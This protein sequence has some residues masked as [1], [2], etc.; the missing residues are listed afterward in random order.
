MNK[1][2]WF[3]QKDA[4]DNSAAALL[5]LTHHLNVRVSRHTIEETLQAH[6][7]YPSLLAL[8]DALTEWNV[9]NTGVNAELEHLESEE[10]SFPAI[11][12][13]KLGFV[14]L[15]GLEDDH[16]RY[17]DLSEGWVRESLEEFGEKWAGTLILAKADETSGEKDYETAR[18]KEILKNLRVPFII[19]AL[20]VLGILSVISGLSLHYY[21]TTTWLPLMIA[22]AVGIG[23]CILLM[24]SQMGKKNS[25]I[26]GVCG[27]SAATSCDDVTESPAGTLF[28]WLHTSELGAFYFAGG[29]LA[30]AFAQFSPEA[31]AVICFLIILNF[32]T[33]PYTLFSVY[34][35]WKVVER[36]C[37]LCLGVMA[38]FWAEFLIFVITYTLETPRITVTEIGIILWGFLTPM[39]L[40]AGIKGE[41]EQSRETPNLKSALAKFKGD[42]ETFS[43]LLNQEEAIEAGELKGDIVLGN[44]EAKMSITMVAGPFCGYCY[45]AYME[46]EKVINEFEEEAK[47]V[48]RILDSAKRDV[49]P[50][51]PF[52]ILQTTGCNGLRPQLPADDC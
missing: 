20:S 48:I 10:M 21:T 8:S 24:M 38:L 7:D 35:Q 14:M 3:R 17:I 26:Q 43:F 33:L 45:A 37:P 2:I 50:Y 15:S 23:L 47:V 46:L 27:F 28:G 30:L 1:E 6:P 39:A 25:L 32:L 31:G 11:A 4:L 49:N 40:W 44:P 18:K 51:A 19:A 41:L 13:T 16:I 29:F 22:K 42:A 9:E 52:P 5:N 34:Y 36:W 12:S